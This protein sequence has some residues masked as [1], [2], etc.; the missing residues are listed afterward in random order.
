MIVLNNER[1]PADETSLLIVWDVKHS[2]LLQWNSDKITFLLICAQ[3][4]VFISVSTNKM[5]KS[6]AF[7]LVS[8]ENVFWWTSYIV[9][10]EL[11]AVASA[12]WN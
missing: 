5:K 1:V 8:T 11:F 3:S 10:I 4:M 9:S 6:I 7:Y 12:E 2:S